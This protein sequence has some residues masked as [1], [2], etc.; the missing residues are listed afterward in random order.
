M[1]PGEDTASA[2]WATAF[3]TAFVL[4]FSFLLPLFL[5]LPEP[6]QDRARRT[7]TLVVL[8]SGGHT[9]EMLSMLASMP[10]AVANGSI[11]IIAGEFY[12][13]LLHQCGLPSVWFASAAGS[14]WCMTG[15]SALNAQLPTR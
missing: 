15:A 13:L 1:P 4:V 5:L 7:R 14:A 8:G 6:A 10:R 9:T 11:F 3:G 12:A 2:E